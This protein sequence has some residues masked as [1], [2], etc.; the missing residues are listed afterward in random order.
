MESTGT[1]DSQEFY[2]LIYCCYFFS[3]FL[4]RHSIC[5]D[6]FR[7]ESLE[8]AQKLDPYTIKTVRRAI[9][10]YLQL[11]THAESKGI[12]VRNAR[13]LSWS[14]LKFMNLKP[15]SEFF[16]KIKDDDI[17][18]FYNTE[19]VQIF[20]SL[21]FFEL[22]SYD[23]LSVLTRPWHELYSRNDHFHE[24]AFREMCDAADPKSGPQRFSL[25]AHVLIEAI[26]DL[27]LKFVISH[28]WRGPLWERRSV[29]KSG[30]VGV[31]MTSEAELYAETSDEICGSFE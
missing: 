5:V 25:P 15:H 26:S 20:R 24:V 13:Q 6:P 28:K 8:F 19:Q 12:D 21:R 17:V 16:D 27:R 29:G 1:D 31:I 2:R 10:G 7:E 14:A 18:E 22:V 9:E 11:L 23:V 30:V 4:Q 3:S